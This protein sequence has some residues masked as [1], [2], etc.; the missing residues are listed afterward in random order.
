MSQSPVR[1]VTEENMI[2]EQLPWGPHEFLCRPDIV[3]AKQLFM[4]RVR[5]PAGQAHQFHRHP[6]CEELIYVLEGTGRQWVDQQSRDIGPGDT[7][8]IPA[9]MVH[10]T[11]NTGDA[12]LVVLAI[13]SPATCEGPMLVDVSQEEPWKS[14]QPV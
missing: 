4:V 13:L 10:G 7:V 1:F 6:E 5:I 11:Y 8:H 12:P 2:V 14:L 9:D 3:E